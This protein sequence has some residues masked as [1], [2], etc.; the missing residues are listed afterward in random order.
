MQEN[1]SKTENGSA[2]YRSTNTSRF[3]HMDDVEIRLECVK[4]VARNST[5]INIY[6]P[7]DIKLAAEDLFW[8]V[9]NGPSYV[10]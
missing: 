2:E 7:D 5:S 6:S 1:E 10:S 3:T 8:Y 4:A 9:K